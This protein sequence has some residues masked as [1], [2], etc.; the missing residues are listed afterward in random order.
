MKK[1]SKISALALMGLALAQPSLAQDAATIEVTPP[2][3]EIG[4]ILN[5][6]MFLVMGFL[7]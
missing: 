5:S 4:Y 6:F 7:V 1:L 2:M 3:V